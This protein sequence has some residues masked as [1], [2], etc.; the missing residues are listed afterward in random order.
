MTEVFL[1]QGTGVSEPGFSTFA[2][3]MAAGPAA[4]RDGLR[5]VP[6]DRGGAHGATLAA[7]AAPYDWLNPYA[8]RGLPASRGAHRSRP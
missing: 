7:R 6:Y 1:I 2:G 3:R 8:P 4:L 5:I